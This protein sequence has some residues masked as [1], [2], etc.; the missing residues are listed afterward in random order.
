MQLEPVLSG[1][2]NDDIVSSF[3]AFLDEAVRD[4]ETLE[5]IIIFIA[6]E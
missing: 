1:H 3:P 5:L 4:S 2:G 6:C